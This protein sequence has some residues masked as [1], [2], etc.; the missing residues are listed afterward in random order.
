MQLAPLLERMRAFPDGLP[1]PSPHPPARTCAPP[2][3]LGP[4]P[5]GCPW[6]LS[7]PVPAWADPTSPGEWG[8]GWGGVRLSFGTGTTLLDDMQLIRVDI[9]VVLTPDAPQFPFGPLLH[10]KRIASG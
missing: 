10:L 3:V 2:G 8:G 5:R 1:L 7:Y 6:G 9:Y 4:R